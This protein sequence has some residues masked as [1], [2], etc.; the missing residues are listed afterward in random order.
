MRVNL[1]RL[2][3]LLAQQCK[4]VSDLRAELS[5]QTLARIRR[6]QDVLPKT[7]GKLARGLGVDVS[8][9]IEKGA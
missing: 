2:D 3:L 8:D 5:P 9:I 1:E 6:G 7:A 4:T